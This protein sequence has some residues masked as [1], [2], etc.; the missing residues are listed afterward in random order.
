MRTL[1]YIG[2]QFPAE[3]PAFVK[4]F[5]EKETTK[6]YSWEQVVELMMTEGV[7]VR[8]IG[9]EENEALHQNVNLIKACCAF[10][11]Q[12]AEHPEQEEA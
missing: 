11:E 1:V 7:T 6:Q 10:L 8:P 5:Q 12:Y 4:P 3:V 9:E 2:E